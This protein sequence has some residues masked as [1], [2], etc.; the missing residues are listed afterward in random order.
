MAKVIFLV[1][2]IYLV[3]YGVRA[4]SA[5]FAGDHAGVVSMSNTAMYAGIVMMI[6]MLFIFAGNAN[7]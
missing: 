7:K 5:V 2:L 4:W 6:S 1:S 3:V